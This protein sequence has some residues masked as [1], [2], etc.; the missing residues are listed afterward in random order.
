[1]HTHIS[2][3][4]SSCHIQTKYVCGDLPGMEGYIYMILI[5]HFN[6]FYSIFKGK[7]GLLAL[8]KHF[9]G[10]NTRL[11]YNPVVYVDDLC[12]VLRARLLVHAKLPCASLLEE[13]ATFNLYFILISSVLKS[14][15]NESQ[16][17][18][19]LVYNFM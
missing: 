13:V 11:M 6:W 2:G 3:C 14:T 15:Q 16:S 12:Y 8:M 1:M 9:T 17:F 5:T 10:W 18:I 4:I 19:L 7:E